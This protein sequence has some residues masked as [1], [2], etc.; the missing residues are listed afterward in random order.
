MTLLEFLILTL[1]IWRIAHL[2]TNDTEDGPYQLLPP[3]RDWLRTNI[4]TELFSCVW[5][6]SIWAGAIVTVSYWLIPVYT[7]WLC[8]PFALSAGAILVDKYSG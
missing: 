3:L 1:A 2:L 7:I 6:F 5:C 4:S 8:L